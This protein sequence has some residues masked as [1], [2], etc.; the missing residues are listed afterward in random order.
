[1]PQPPANADADSPIEFGVAGPPAIE[2]ARCG[3][4]DPDVYGAQLEL[5]FPVE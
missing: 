2:S 1:M 4:S 3:T 5:R